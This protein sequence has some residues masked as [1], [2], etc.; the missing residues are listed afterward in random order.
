METTD[1]DFETAINPKG[2]RLPHPSRNKPSSAVAVPNEEGQKVE[3]SIVIMRSAS[4]VYAFLKDFFNYSKFIPSLE[5]VIHVAGGWT[6][7]KAERSSWNG[8]WNLSRTVQ[9]S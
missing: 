3:A 2:G 8:I 9:V 7:W 1:L 4:E 5:P 6:H